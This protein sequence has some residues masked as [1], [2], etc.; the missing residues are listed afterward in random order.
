MSKLQIKN[1]SKQFGNSKVL[2]NINIDVADGDFVVLVGPSGSGKSTILR[3]IAG[4]EHP[5]SGIVEINNK[6]VNN[7]PPKERDI[8][9]VFQNYALYPHMSVYDN[10]AFPLKMKNVKS[11]TIKNKVFETAELLGVKNYLIKKPKELSGGERQRIALGRAIIRNPQLFLMDEPL[12]N[13][14]AKLR[15]QMRAELLK[16]HKALSATIVYVTHDQIEALTMGNK[17]IVLNHGS[18]QQIGSPELVY[19]KPENHFVASFIGSPAMNFFKI[20]ILSNIKIIF[21]GRE[22]D[23]NK[24]PKLVNNKNYYN[25]EIVLGIRPEH[26]SLARDGDLT[27]LASVDLIEMLGNEYLIYAS[28]LDNKNNK[29]SFSIKTFGSC[30]LK[31]NEKITVSLQLNEA[32]CF[33]VNSGI[34]IEI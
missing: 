22:Y 6:I 32:H 20:K 15:T 30:N 7:L 10:L 16:L 28:A 12:S 29:I 11:E 3:V 26:V 5:D 4:L 31:P 27:F 24:S 2:N 18:I 1:L 9:M 25:K 8:A 23:L 14:D 21:L 33:D 19:L 13:L 34:R 17:I